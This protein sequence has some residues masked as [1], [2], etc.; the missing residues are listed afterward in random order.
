VKLFIELFHRLIP[1]LPR[2]MIGERFD[3][4]KAELLLEHTD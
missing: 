1:D 2:N 4:L 3:V